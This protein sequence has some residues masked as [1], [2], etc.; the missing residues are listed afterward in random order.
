MPL[1]TYYF[2]GL[3]FAVATTLYTD[4]LMSVVAPDGYYA[5]GGTVR[6]QVNGLLLT[7]VTCPGCF[8]TC[9]NPQ[10]NAVVSLG[11]DVGR[12]ELKVDSGSKFSRAVQI[13]MLRAKTETPKSRELNSFFV[14]LYF[15]ETSLSFTNELS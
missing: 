11:S 2:E 7:A 6:R 1:T 14:F 13:T 3:D 4:A 12:M 10:G 8:I 15:N 5:G 9:G